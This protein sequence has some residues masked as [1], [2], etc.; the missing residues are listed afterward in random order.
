[1]GHD[2]NL[3][4]QQNSINKVKKFLIYDVNCG[5]VLSIAL[6]YFIDYVKVFA[7]SHRK[8]PCDGVGGTVKRLAL[9]RSLQRPSEK[10]ILFRM[11]LFEF[12]TES[13]M[14]ILFEFVNV[15]EIIK[16][17]QMLEKRLLKAATIV[18]IVKH[19]TFILLTR[20]E[21]K[22]TIRTHS[23]A[24]EGT[25]VKV[26]NKLDRP[27][28]EKLLL[29]AYTCIYDQNWWVCRILETFKENGEVQFKFLHPKGLSSFYV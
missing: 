17:S 5:P 10:Q 20:S 29:G 23:S 14:G 1:M 24:S 4:P 21:A 22:L 18:G 2:S 3:H 28:F 27:Q 6:L 25:V 7:T 12:A 16:E 15:E 19:H 13:I 9:R 8:G 26:S 11:T